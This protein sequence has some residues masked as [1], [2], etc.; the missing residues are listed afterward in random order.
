VGEP[1]TKIPV[2]QQILVD[3]G[4]PGLPATCPTTSPTRATRSIVPIVPTV[5]TN[6]ILVATVDHTE[7]IKQ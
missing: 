3:R 1:V 6:A 4:T 7:L 5:A 2:S